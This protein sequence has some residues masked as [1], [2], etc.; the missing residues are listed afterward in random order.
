MRRERERKGIIL[1]IVPQ[2]NCDL[3]FYSWNDIT[4]DQA[5]LSTQASTGIQ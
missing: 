5:N 1:E 3:S 2:F 4:C